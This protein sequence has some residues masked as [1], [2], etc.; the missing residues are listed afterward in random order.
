MSSFITTGSN[1]YR[2]SES[3]GLREERE[4]SSGLMVSDFFAKEMGAG[5]WALEC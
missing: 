3:V 4:G 5:G 1:E 2:F